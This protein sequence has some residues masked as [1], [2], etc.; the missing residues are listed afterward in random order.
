MAGQRGKPKGKEGKGGMLSSLLLD[1]ETM[2]L[3]I[4]KNVDSSV[5][6]ESEVGC[7]PNQLDQSSSKV[8]A[9]EADTNRRRQEQVD[10]SSAKKG[11][12]WKG[13][14]RLVFLQIF[15]SRAQHSL[16]MNGEKA[17]LNPEYPGV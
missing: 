11:R 6:D 9:E 15:V 12:P 8:D 5:S 14:Q 1:P 16:S 10:L 3:S 17:R 4:L 2:A 7:S 13:G